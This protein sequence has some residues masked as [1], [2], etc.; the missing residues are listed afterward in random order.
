[1][2]KELFAVPAA[3]GLFFVGFLGSRLTGYL[4]SA[5]P[6]SPHNAQDFNPALESSEYEGIFYKSLPMHLL[7]ALSN[8]ELSNPNAQR[9]IKEIP[10]FYKNR[11]ALNKYYAFSVHQ[12]LLAAFNVAIDNN[13]FDIMPYE[14]QD[15]L[16]QWLADN[17]DLVDLK[18]PAILDFIKKATARPLDENLNFSVDTEEAI[19]KLCNLSGVSRESPRKAV[20]HSLRP[21]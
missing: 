10:D 17:T 6:G 4:P 18:S 16:I 3:A 11:A 5:I 12:N 14:T 15:S 19:D 13:L 8:D 21:K 2:R 9:I 20:S 7:Y 1:M